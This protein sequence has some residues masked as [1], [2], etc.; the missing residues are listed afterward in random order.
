MCRVLLR[1]MSQP[2]PTAPQ[3]QIA[4]ARAC[5]GCQFGWEKKLD[6]LTKIWGKQMYCGAQN[7]YNLIT[8]ISVWYHIFLTPTIQNGLNGSKCSFHIGLYRLVPNNNGDLHKCSWFLQAGTTYSK[9]FRKYLV[10]SKKKNKTKLEITQRQ[11][12]TNYFPPYL[13]RF[14]V[15]LFFSWNI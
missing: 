15:N 13:H 7:N 1:R 12:S 9:P 11:G 10:S 6:F 8:I 2:H 5:A 3:F 14:K 4:L